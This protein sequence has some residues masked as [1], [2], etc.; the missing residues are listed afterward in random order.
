[1]INLF[2][3]RK[4]QLTRATDA[5]SFWINNGA[6]C[7]TLKDL[8]SALEYMSDE[9]FFYHVTKEKNDFSLWT[10]AVLK[11]KACAA[12]L[13][14]VRTRKSTIKKLETCLEGYKL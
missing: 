13:K 11:D 10:A 5:T 4:K 2:M 3:G 12:A 7:H 8:H 14:K 1:V 9:Q 6:V